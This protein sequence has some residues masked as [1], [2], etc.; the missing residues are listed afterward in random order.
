MIINKQNIMGIKKEIIEGTK[1]ICEIESTNLTKTD[2]D[3]ISKTF[4]N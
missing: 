4:K 2:Y 1:I 3:T